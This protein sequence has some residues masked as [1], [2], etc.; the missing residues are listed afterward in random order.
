[1]VAMAA[2]PSFQDIVHALG[3]RER[4]TSSTWA[5]WIR[6]RRSPRKIFA[7]ADAAAQRRDVWLMLSVSTCPLCAQMINTWATQFASLSSVIVAS[8]D[9]P[10]K[11]KGA[12][13]EKEEGERFEGGWNNVSQ[14]EEKC[15]LT[16]N[17][18]RGWEEKQT[19]EQMAQETREMTGERWMNALWSFGGGE[20]IDTAV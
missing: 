1:M 12:Y 13:G 5:L 10:L 16:L 17:K 14:V 9:E 15:H 4:E 20:D 3:G 11:N 6:G 18:K 8:L 7:E 2:G 19:S